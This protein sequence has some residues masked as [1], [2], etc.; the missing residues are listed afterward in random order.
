[1]DLKAFAAGGRQGVDQ[2]LETGSKKPLIAAIEGL[3]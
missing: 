3:L 1:M 2:F